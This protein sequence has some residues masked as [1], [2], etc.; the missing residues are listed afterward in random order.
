M[1]A[2]GRLEM[3]AVIATHRADDAKIVD[4]FGKVGEKFADFDPGFAVRREIPVWPLDVTFF[5][6]FAVIGNELWFGIERVDMRDAAAHIKEDDS[7]RFCGKMWRARR[8]WIFS[9]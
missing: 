8:E 3:V 6:L 5:G 9:D 7:L 4:A 2:K 1:N